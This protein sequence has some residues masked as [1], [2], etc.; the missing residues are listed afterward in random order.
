M[1]ASGAAA[2]C[3]QA[4]ES[5]KLDAF[6]VGLATAV[7]KAGFGMVFTWR[8]VRKR[9]LRARQLRDKRHDQGYCD[10]PHTK[11]D[12]QPV[13]ARTGYKY[14][15][16]SVGLPRLLILFAPPSE[17][18]GAVGAL[19]GY[20]SDSGRSERE[21]IRVAHLELGAGTR[22]RDSRRSVI[23]RIAITLSGVSKACRAAKCRNQY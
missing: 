9:Q 19:C 18:R 10:V 23:R 11:N 8:L 13:H 16:D 14:G 5:R 1:T 22:T 17:E 7:P 20:R 4:R 3:V 21:R 15:A 6:T 12:E 2:L